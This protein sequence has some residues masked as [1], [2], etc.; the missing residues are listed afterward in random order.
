MHVLM[1][2]DGVVR[3][4]DPSAARHL[5][6]VTGLSYEPLLRLAVSQPELAAAVRGEGTSTEWRAAVVR[7]LAGEGREGRREDRQGPVDEWL[8]HPGV[9]DDE[10][11]AVLT[12]VDQEHLHLSTNST[13]RLEEDLGVL[14]VRSR[15]SRV[16]A[17]HRMHR[18]KPDPAYFHEVMSV[19]G[20]PPS[21]VLLVDDTPAN[22]AAA[23]AAGLSAHLHRSADELQAVLADLIPPDAPGLAKR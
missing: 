20:V 12:R 6:T 19:L 9:L 13:D 17:S 5:V 22:V 14:G 23:R 2:L 4:R 3:H 1:D 8:T 7:A 21:Q 16:F 18:A 11:M 10:V 15:F